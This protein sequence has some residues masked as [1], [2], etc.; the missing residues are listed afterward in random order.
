MSTVNEQVEGVDEGIEQVRHL[1]A[2]Q[3]SSLLT[4]PENQENLAIIV[5]GALAR[6]TKE[7]TDTRLRNANR[8][9]LTKTYYAGALRA[10]VGV[11]V[12][13]E[14]DESLLSVKFFIKS[15]ENEWVPADD[16]NDA[17]VENLTK[18]V[19][20]QTAVPG[21]VFYI[22][23]QAAVNQFVD[24]LSAAMTGETGEQPTQTQE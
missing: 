24:N 11:S 8:L 23:T 21:D 10:E 12:A 9:T 14:A 7:L 16:L 22:T 18:L 2:E 3:L 13:E 5:V 1:I 4:I 17:A 20:S 6:M 15:E 19:L